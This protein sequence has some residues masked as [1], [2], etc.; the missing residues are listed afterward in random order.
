MVGVLV[1]VG[2]TTGG[3]LAAVALDRVGEAA[4]VRA[5]AQRVAPPAATDPIPA[6][7]AAVVTVVNDERVRLGLTPYEWHADVAEAAQGHSDYM[8]ARA[9][10]SH[11]GSGGS[12]AGDRLTAAGFQWSGWGE[13]LAAG[14]VDV[15]A[16]FQDWWES[17]AHRPQLIGDWTYIGVG[18]AQ[19]ANG[20]PYWTLVVA[21]P[22]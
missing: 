9:R 19:S 13:N 17:T 4:T 7:V 8:A 14:Q 10:V 2:A 6:D 15:G 20:T 1:V 5:P 11:S 3:A 12:N 18:M 22:A 21:D 16:L